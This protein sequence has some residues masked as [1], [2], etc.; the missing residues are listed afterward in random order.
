MLVMNGDEY[1]RKLKN[2]EVFYCFQ[3]YRIIFVKI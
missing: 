3:K 2:K 1:L